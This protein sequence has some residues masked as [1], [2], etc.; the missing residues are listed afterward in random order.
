MFVPLSISVGLVQIARVKS[1]ENNRLAIG[2]DKV[3]DLHADVRDLG[4]SRQR[5]QNGSG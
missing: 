3:T 4:Q 1:T 2:G 5:K